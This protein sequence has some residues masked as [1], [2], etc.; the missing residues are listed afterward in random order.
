MATI[1]KNV[2]DEFERMLEDIKSKDETQYN[3]VVEMFNT[4]TRQ[5]NSNEHQDLK[6]VLRKLLN[7][8]VDEFKIKGK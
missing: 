7:N 1:D 5:I 4:L 8:H 6:P 2:L 3:I